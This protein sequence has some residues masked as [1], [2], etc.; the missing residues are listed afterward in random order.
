MRLHHASVLFFA[1]LLAACTPA[2]PPREAPPS[3]VTVDSAAATTA[4]PEETQAAVTESA[5]VELPTPTPAPPVEAVATLAPNAV[6]LRLEPVYQ[7]FEL[8]V[9]FTDAGDGSGRHFVVEKTGKIWAIDNGQIVA[10]PFLDLSAKITVRG[11]EQGL[12]GMAFAPDYATSGHF[13]VNYTDTA[14]ADD[15]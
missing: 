10:E 7:G 4:A 8:P 3:A 13:F 11:N 9:F 2:L 12:L 6:Q 5:A 14:G 15:G 1:M